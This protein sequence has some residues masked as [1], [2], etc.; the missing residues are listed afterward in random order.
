MS[1][2]ITKTQRDRHVLQ[3]YINR[4]CEHTSQHVSRIVMYCITIMERMGKHTSQQYM[5]RM[6]YH[7]S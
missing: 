6:F 5:E 4:I 2:I 1:A 3:Q 7:A